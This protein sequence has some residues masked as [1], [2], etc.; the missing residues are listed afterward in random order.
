MD[1]YTSEQNKGDYLLWQAF[2]SIQENN[3][4]SAV[5]RTVPHCTFFFLHYGYERCHA[6]NVLW[7]LMAAIIQVAQGATFYFM[8]ELDRLTCE[9]YVYAAWNLTDEL[10]RPTLFFFFFFFYKYIFIPKFSKLLHQC[11]FEE[12][13]IT[14]IILETMVT[15]RYTHFITLTYL[16]I[17]LF[18]RLSATF[19]E[20][21]KRRYTVTVL[22][23]KENI[24]LDVYLLI[25]TKI[26]EL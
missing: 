16:F 18:F 21:R 7:F 6:Q 14:D 23:A 9:L 22:S 15:G 5:K 4:D 8:K 10:P 24:K 2:K 1:K 26:D 3:G 19:T 17:R 20:E 13:Y 25:T 11:L 12:T